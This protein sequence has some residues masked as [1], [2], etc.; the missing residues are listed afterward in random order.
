MTVLRY[1]RKL[2]FKPD[3]ALRHKIC[4]HFKTRF[5]VK[6][7][8]WPTL[9]DIDKRVPDTLPKWCKVRVK[10]GGDAI[11]GSDAMPNPDTSRDSSFVRV[12]SVRLMHLLPT[13]P[14]DHLL[15]QFSQLVDRNERFPKRPVLLERQVRYGQL[16]SIMVCTLPVSNLL[17]LTPQSQKL[18]LLAYITPVDTSVQRAGARTWPDATEEVVSYTETRET[19]IIVDVSSVECVVGRVKYKINGRARW[20]I[21]DRSGDGARTTFGE[22][23]AWDDDEDNN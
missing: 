12:S 17:R 6:G 23:E 16:H 8:E 15:V 20:G 10:H 13:S 4:V 9:Q 5:G 3:S 2:E 19:S 21:I 22:D 11:R 7:S 1:P 18:F 14:P